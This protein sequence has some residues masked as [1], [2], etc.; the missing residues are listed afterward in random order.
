MLRKN[1]L[2]RLAVLV[3]LALAGV[4]LVAACNEREVRKDS[5]VTVTSAPAPIAAGASAGQ[6]AGAPSPAESPLACATLRDVGVSDLVRIDGT[7]LFYADATA[8]LT[9]VDVS[10]AAKPRVLSVVPFVG[11]PLALFVREGVAWVVFVDPDSRSGKQ[12]LATVI[13]AVDVKDPE[14]PRTLGSEVREGT[15]RDAKLVGGLL[16]VMRGAMGH[17]VVEG[18]GIKQDKLRVL[19]S[20]DVDGAPAQLA[21]SSAGL[22]VVTTSDDHA[23]V[24][25]V[26]LSMERPGS[27]LLRQSVRVPG[28]VA[29]WERG[30]SKLASADDGQR[31]RLVTCASKGCTPGEAA[32]LRIVDFS[33]DA[34]Q[35]TMTS[36]RLTEHDGLPVTR[37]V[38]GLLYVVESAPPSKDASTL[39]VVR[40]D[41]RVPR[42]VAH[43]PLRGR[44]SAIVPRDGS[45]VALGAVGAP[46]TQVKIILHD[47]DVRKPAAPRT[48]SSVV[49]GSDWTWSIVADDDRAM[50]FDP[51]SH[52]LAVPFTAWRHEDKK[53]VTGAQIVDVRPLGAQAAAALPVDGWVERA[54]FLDGHLVTLGPNGVSSIDYASTHAPDLAERPLDLGR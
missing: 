49:F 48:R 3:P 37:F 22:A 44:L 26:D 36:L 32:T 40:T 34:P 7:T 12:G 2:A 27:M 24:A 46:A 39:H 5:T 21:A 19:D 52:L 14:H 6:G 11:T 33:K 28:G 53:Y 15:A 20:V 47:I 18:F 10:D 17:A 29:T 1:H 41:D 13:R 38:D 9:A 8:G 51:A 4:A 30:D 43:L 42:I 50:S 16:Y 54:V 23:T 31:V 35:R 25:W 45:L